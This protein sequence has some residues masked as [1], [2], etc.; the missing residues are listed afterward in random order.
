MAEYVRDDFNRTTGSGSPGALGTG[1]LGGPWSVYASASYVGWRVDGSRARADFDTGSGGVAHAQV[2]SASPAV[3]AHGA[4]AVRSSVDLMPM[5]AQLWFRTNGATA[6]FAGYGI[7]VVRPQSGVGCSV[8]LLR[9]PV[10]SPTVIGT[11]AAS[12]AWPVAYTNYVTIELELV[13]SAPTTVR[14]RWFPTASPPADDTGWV[15]FNDSTGPQGAGAYGMRLTRSGTGA[16]VLGSALVGWA[17]VADRLIPATP[18]R[19]MTRG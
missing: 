7:R 4:I 9:G 15:Q 1:Y 17:Y 11:V 18:R 8:D 13:G 5:A 10:D 14:G 6:T 3:A 19:S 2:A 12:F 16:T